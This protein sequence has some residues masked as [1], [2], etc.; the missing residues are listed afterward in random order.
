MAEVCEV[1]GADVNSSVESDRLRHRGSGT[2]SCAPG[3]GFGGGC[4][5]KDIRAFIARAGEL[6]VDQAV[7]FLREVDEINLRRRARTLESASTWST[8]RTAGRGWRCWARRSS[9][10]ATT[11][12]TRR[13]S[14]S[15]PRSA[16]TA[17]TSWSTTRRRWRT[18]AVL[19]R[20]STY[21][22]SL[23]EAVTG[24]DVL[25]VL[26]E[27]EEFQVMDPEAV[28][29]RVAPAQHRRRPQHP[30]PGGVARRRLALPRPGPSLAGT[31]LG[32]SRARA[33]RSPG[34]PKP[35]RSEARA[36]RS[37]GCPK[38]GGS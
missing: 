6:G 3:L 19:T 11:S 34:G 33:V 15:P 32:R 1:T 5:P 18:P 4:L 25:L 22:N 30:R 12:A 16:D 26:T 13:P 27:W 17:P 10:T 36:V 20:S 28:G 14:T 2:G 37:P 29:E 23:D 31:K 21:V 8:A 9:R 24:A 35:G 38:P 7:S